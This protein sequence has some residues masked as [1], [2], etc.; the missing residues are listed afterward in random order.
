MTRKTTKAKAED[1]QLF[2]VTRKQAL[3]LAAFCISIEM[4][5]AETLIAVILNQLGDDFSP[6]KIAEVKEWAR[7]IID[8]IDSL[9]STYVN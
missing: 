4:G 3:T 5:P 1:Q 6:H 8:S 7:E 9:G 2:M